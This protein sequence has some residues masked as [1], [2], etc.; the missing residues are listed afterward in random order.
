MKYVWLSVLLVGSLLA[1]GT[2]DSETN[3]NTR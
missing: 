1:A 2:E 3:V